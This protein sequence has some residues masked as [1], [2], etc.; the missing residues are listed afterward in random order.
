MASNASK[1]I[2]D[3]PSSR[4]STPA[5][6]IEFRVGK[7]GLADFFDVNTL[8]SDSH[9]QFLNWTVD[10][11]GAYDYAANT[12]GYTDGAILEYGDHWFTARFAEALMP[13]VANGLYLDAD[14][15]RSRAENLEL[16]ARGKRVRTAQ[17]LCA[18][19]RFLNHADMG[20]LREAIEDYLDQRQRQPRTSFPRG[21][22]G[23]TNM[24]SD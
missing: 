22:K 11:N 17:E 3:E 16:E 18:C 24:A 10:N 7:F 15:A 14:L 4:D 1:P 23:G 9:L 6:R 19:S 8:G 2:V 13:K 5:R 21:A 20:K 12:R